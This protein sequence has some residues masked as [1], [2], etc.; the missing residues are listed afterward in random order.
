MH[1]CCINLKS[2]GC[3]TKNGVQILESVM[4]CASSLNFKINNDIVQLNGLFSYDSSHLF[5]EWGGAAGRTH[6]R[7]RCRKILFASQ[8]TIASASGMHSKSSTRRCVFPS[9]HHRL[10]IA[11]RIFS[12]LPLQCL[13]LF[14][15]RAL[16]TTF[17][18]WGDTVLI[19]LIPLANLL[20]CKFLI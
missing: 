15:S 6:H 11:V 19:L 13:D 17:T 9:R 18:S 10:S 7:I 16:M 1:N 8:N 2:A 20:V 5:R 4:F 3:L 14:I 12:Y